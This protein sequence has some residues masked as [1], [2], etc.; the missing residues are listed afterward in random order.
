MDDAITLSSGSDSG[1]SDVEIIGAYTE[2]KADSKPFVKGDLVDVSTSGGTP[3]FIDLT[4]P[5]LVLPGPRRRKRQHS[6][7][8]IKV[9]NVTHGDGT[10]RTE[11]TLPPEDYGRKYGNGAKILRSHRGGSNSQETPSNSSSFY[12]LQDCD[13]PKAR[14]GHFL[15]YVAETPQQKQT[16][17]A[18]HS[19][20]LVNTPV[21][22]LRRLPLPEARIRELKTSRYSARLPEDCDQLSSCPEKVVSHSIAPECINLRT[23]TLTKAPQLSPLVDESP[24]VFEVENQKDQGSRL[25]SLEDILS[26]P[27]QSLDNSHYLDERN[28]KDCHTCESKRTDFCSSPLVPSVTS[29]PLSQDVQGSYQTNLSSSKHSLPSFDSGAQH[30]ELN[31]SESGQNLLSV[32]TS[33][34]VPSTGPDPHIPQHVDLSH[35]PCTSSPSHYNTCEG[36]ADPGPTAEDTL[37]GKTAIWQAEEAEAH[38]GVDGPA[39]LGNDDPPPSVTRTEDLDGGSFRGDLGVESPVH[40]DWSEGEEANH[41]SKFDVN[42]RSAS[43]ED[44]RYVCP[45]ALS[46][47]ISRGV[48]GLNNNEEE[49]DSFGAPEVLC[50]QSLSLVYSTIEESYTE[51]TLQ[52]LSDLLQP[53]YYPP[54]D[55]TSH[56]LRGVL[57]DLQ[58][59][60]HLCVQ[61]FNLLMRTQRHH[62]ADK[63][64]IPWDWEL[65]TS[66][67]ANQDHDKRHRCEVVRMF[68][69]YVVQ[70]LEDDFQAKVSASALRR[71]IAK[72][73]LSC[74]LHF[75]QVKDVIKWLFAAIM[76]SAECE[77][78][79]EVA[80]ER[81][82]HIRMVSAFQR[83]LALALEVDRSPGL[84]A[85]KLSQELFHMLVHTAPLRT[86][87]MLL[88][89]SLQSKLLRC[90]LLEHLLDYACPQ[91]TPLPMSLSLLLHFLKNCTLKPD[92]MD[93]AER[94]R[95]WEE[96]IQLLWMLML[97]YIRVMKGHLC[98]PVTERPANANASVNKPHDMLCRS[99]VREA[100]ESFLSRSHA[101]LGQA[102]PLH[103]EESLTYL[104]DHL[105]DVCQF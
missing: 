12:P 47:I 64:T 61:A 39:C 2:S 31:Q 56:L 83:M 90:K 4:D 92:H 96:L 7:D 58:C 57:L 66:V 71:S 60:Q 67:M 14:Q 91:K 42:F 79:E 13:V 52:L 65:L 35:H 68:L 8:S 86:H 70:T 78:S 76:K 97:S 75:T 48:Q 84:N 16:N 44:R 33:P 15:E 37:A 94:W 45:A 95:R 85:D 74:D 22:I 20:V 43:R 53:G 38:L 55:I 103:V 21:V 27:L 51:G 17:E 98:S 82:E 41:E 5:T 32:R 40:V 25:S 104:Q 30:L 88:L 36:Q 80:K 18:N 1:D 72:A 11:Q 62:M 105:L 59:P 101:D 69:E 46:K 102:L 99:T 9:L 6:S 24:E 23:T 54:K 81:H 34:C 29:S 28:S 100:V 19:T 63:T 10:N 49:E 3:L 93:G 89:E 50:R 87:R 77:H 26:L 73:T